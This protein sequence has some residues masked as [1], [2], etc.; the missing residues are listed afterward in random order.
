[1]SNVRKQLRHGVTLGSPFEPLAFPTYAVILL[2]GVAGMFLMTVSHFR[3]DMQLVRIFLT[4]SLSLIVAAWLLRSVGHRRTAGAIEAVN[5]VYSQGVVFLFVLYPLLAL[6]GPYTDDLLSGMDAMLGFDWARFSQWLTR[7]Q[8]LLRSIRYA[9]ASFEWQPLFIV[10]LLAIYRLE[11]RMWTFALA[12][13]AA[14]AVTSVIFAFFPAEGAFR[15]SGLSGSTFLGLSGKTSWYFATVVH[16]VKDQGV[17]WLDQHLVAGIV[18]FP[19]YHTA[20]ALINAWATWPM[21]RMRW[22]F[23][24]VNVAMVLAAIGFGAH[25]LVDIIAGA[26]VGGLAIWVA[27]AVLL[28]RPHMQSGAEVVS[29]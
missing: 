18:S 9:Y 10:P 27:R 15:H 5:L 1:M 19:S 12:C 17:R 29:D 2:A 22:P 3:A 21:R 7:H 14:L 25:Y 20:V 26:M 24:L 16:L 4:W 8:A 6:S 13:S 23:L 28:R 11:V